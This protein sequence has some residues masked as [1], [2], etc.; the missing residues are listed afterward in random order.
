MVKDAILCY[1]KV[2]KLKPDFAEAHN[3]M[4][5]ALVKRGDIEAAIRQFKEALKIKP[6]YSAPRDNLKKI[7]E[8][9]EK[10]RK[11]RNRKD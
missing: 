1:E 7:F 11:T 9:V 8:A 5:A 4:G 10:N 3:N 2:L 6:Y